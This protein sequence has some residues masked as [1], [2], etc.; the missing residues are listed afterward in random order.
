MN[1]GKKRIKKILYVAG[2]DE[3]GRGPLAG[4]VV[5]AAVILHPIRPIQGLADSKVL[6]P[7]RRD[8]LFF[9]I[10]AK[11]RAVGVGRASV[12]EIDRMNIFHAS[13]LAMQRAVEAIDFPLHL[14]LVDGTH[15]PKLRCAARAIVRGDSSVPAISA[16]SIVAKVTRDWEMIE[17]HKQYPHY[18]FAEH[19][20]YPT[21]KHL[22][23]LAQHGVS[24]FH[25]RSYGPVRRLLYATV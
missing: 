9:E 18:G 13:L 1:F 21:Q 7:A 23:A 20:G 5:A 25:R 10:R 11:A 8:D 12:E 22:N 16:A 19:K 2:V 14:A 24:A 4:P 15:T 3:A 6:S 17:L